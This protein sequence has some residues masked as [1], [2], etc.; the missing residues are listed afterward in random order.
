MLEDEN[1]DRDKFFGQLVSKELREGEH[2]CDF[3]KASQ[4]KG[5]YGLEPILGIRKLGQS[6][7]QV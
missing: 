6:Q 3:Q 1:G 4:A 7:I 2:G 5:I